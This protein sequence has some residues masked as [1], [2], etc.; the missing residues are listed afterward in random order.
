[1]NVGEDVGAKAS[2]ARSHI[3]QDVVSTKMN[4]SV[5]RERERDKRINADDVDGTHCEG[6]DAECFN[7]I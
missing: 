5:C 7:R 1:M 6:S 4:E 2:Q 3:D